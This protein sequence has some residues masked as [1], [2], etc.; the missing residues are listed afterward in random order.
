MKK[1]NADF[2]VF[3]IKQA[4]E[5]VAFG[6]TLNHC[7]RNLKIALMQYWQN[8]QLHLH[9]TAQKK[10]MLRSQAALR[11]PLNKCRVEHAVPF[12]V[13]IDRLMKMK[14][15]TANGVTKLL[16]KWYVIRLVTQAEDVRLRES[17]LRFK[18]PDN[19]NGKDVFARYKAVGIKMAR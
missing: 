8:K 9:N 4:K 14:P 18:M 12:T 13:I 15:L 3:S 7:N 17:G 6:N 2:I 10:R 19:W 11:L 1:T 5:A 16:K